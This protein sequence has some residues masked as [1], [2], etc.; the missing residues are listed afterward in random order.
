MI[1]VW[2]LLWHC[3]ETFN[4]T[5]Y[6]LYGFG[7]VS[8][9]SY[10]FMNFATFR[11]SIAKLETIFRYVQYVIK[12]HIY[13]Q[14]PKNRWLGWILD[15]DRPYRNS[16]SSSPSP[17][18]WLTVRC[19]IGNVKLQNDYLNMA[20]TR[21]TYSKL[22]IKSFSTPIFEAT[23]FIKIFKINSKCTLFAILIWKVFSEV[24]VLIH[25]I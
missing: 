4:C 6:T 17:P 21:F 18:S 20:R 7:H 11:S 3:P 10:F 24:Y 14:H 9:L 15:N 19:L 22:K 25:T 12:H 2:N 8:W 13:E 5:V 23:F 16:S 1:Q